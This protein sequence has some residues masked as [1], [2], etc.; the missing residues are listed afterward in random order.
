M[1]KTSLG[2][3]LSPFAIL[4]MGSTG[5]GI[6]PIGSLWRLIDAGLANTLLLLV[7]PMVAPGII[8]LWPDC[9]TQVYG[10]K[11]VHT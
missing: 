4:A 6:L 1:L 5:F 2:S 11:T 10:V 7:G 3:S 9:T 8:A